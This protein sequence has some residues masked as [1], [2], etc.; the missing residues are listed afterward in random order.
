[1]PDELL[2]CRNTQSLSPDDRHILATLQTTVAACTE[3]L[4]RFRFND[5]AHDLYEFVWHAYCDWYVETSKEVLY[6]EDADRKAQVLKVM[7]YTMGVCL[8]LLHPFMPFLTEELWH[9]FDYGGDDDT[10]L[11]SAWP[12]P[13]DTATLSAWG[14]TAEIAAYVEGVKSNAYNLGLTTAS[15]IPKRGLIVS[16]HRNGRY[17][18]HDPRTE[19]EPITHAQAWAKFQNALQK[20]KDDNSHGFCTDPTD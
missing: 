11:F 10:I 9:A 8:R 2:V 14:A 4:E 5:A 13:A 16:L 12:V 6:G 3:N 15:E 20:F 19:R 18:I 1:M 7:Q 17:T